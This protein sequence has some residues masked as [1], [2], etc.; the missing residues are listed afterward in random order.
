MKNKKSVPEEFEY[1]HN[2]PPPPFNPSYIK[3]AEMKN[4]IVTS[5]LH[6][7][8]FYLKHTRE[9]CSIEW[10]RVYDLTPIPTIMEYKKASEYLYNLPDVI[11]KNTEESPEVIAPRL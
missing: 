7:R 11:D 3:G 1:Q 2:N 9:E 5:D 10:R 4:A 8:E 6:R